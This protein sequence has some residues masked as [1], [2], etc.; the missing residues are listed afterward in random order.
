LEPAG[1]NQLFFRKT[2][3]EVTGTV[4]IEKRKEK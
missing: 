4:F 1:P 2:K 3:I